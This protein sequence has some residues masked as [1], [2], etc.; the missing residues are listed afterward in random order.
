M[1]EPAGFQTV[2]LLLERL[3]DETRALRAAVET[4]APPTAPAEPENLWTAK[5]T[6]EFLGCSPSKVYQA[7]EAG[8]LPCLH[9]VGQ[10]RF[11]PEAVRRWA[12]GE[13]APQTTVVPFPR[14]QAR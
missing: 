13:A 12:R 9:I 11:E 7:A 10:L 2:A 4:K 14:V 1:N 3:L 8:V 5:R 6:A